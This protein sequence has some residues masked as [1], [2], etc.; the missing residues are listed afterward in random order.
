MMLGSVFRIDGVDCLTDTI[1]LIR[2]TLCDHY[3][4][5][6]H[7]LFDFMRK[8]DALN[9]LQKA[10]TL[11]KQLLPPKHPCLGTTYINLG[12]VYCDLRNYD[13]ALTYYQVSYE[14]FH[15]SLSRKHPSVARA[16]KNIAAIHELKGDFFKASIYYH[17]ALHLHQQILHPTHP[18]LK[19]IKEDIQ[20]VLSKI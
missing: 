4:P 17:K 10:F 20:R 3:D 8:N 14:I 11:K 16:Q 2:M 9:Y 7:L 6:F 5:K 13:L 19:E 1:K 15:T 12:N 18:D